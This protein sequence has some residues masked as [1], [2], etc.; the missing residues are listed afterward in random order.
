MGTISPRTWLTEGRERLGLDRKTFGM[1]CGASEILIS[2]LEDRLTITHP[3]IAARAVRLIGG[4]VEQY[5]SIVHKM[6][7][8]KKLPKAPKLPGGEVLLPKKCMWCETAFLGHNKNQRF[9]SISCAG[10]YRHHHDKEN[11]DE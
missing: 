11:K 10:L 5:N 8:A 6:H 1:A 9:C 3:N 2:W 4:T 7:N